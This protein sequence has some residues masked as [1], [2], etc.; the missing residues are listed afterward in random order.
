MRTKCILLICLLL[1]VFSAQT[2]SV[3][4]AA[5]SALAVKHHNLDS[6]Y[7]CLD[8]AVQQSPRYVAER[9]GRIAK[10]TQQ[11]RSCRSDEAR[12]KLCFSLFREYSAYKNDS[13]VNYL[14]RCISIAQRMG[15]KAKEGN[16]KALL[17]FQSSTT[18]DY[19]ESYSLL[20]KMD[21]TQLDKEGYCNYLWSSQHLYNELA[22]Y[23]KVPS[24]KK[25]YE[26]MLKKVRNLISKNFAPND[27]RYLQMQ[28]VEARD[29]QQYERALALNDRRMNQVKPGSHEYAI[30]AYY[31]AVIYKNM[32][33]D[34]MAMYYFL[35]T[36]LCDVR[37][38]V[39]DQGSLWE[40]ANLLS[41]N[42]QEFSRSYAYMK[43]AWNSAVTFNT[44]VRTRQIMPLLSN[45]EDTYQREVMQSNKQL[46]I[47]IVISVILLLLVLSLLL[48]VN[49][50]R[51]RLSLAHKKLELANEQL[52]HANSQLEYANQQLA[53]ANESLE[54]TNADLQ[55]S[56][57]N[58][59]QAYTE[60]GESNKMKEVYIGR[61]L[62]LCAIYVDKI[63]TLRKRVI[64]LVRQRE[65]TKLLDT[66]QADHE[67]IGELY[68]YFDSA[69]LKLF[70]DFV[71][72]FNALLKPEERIQLEDDRKL[73]TT[74]RIFALIRLGIEDSSKI[75]EFLHYSVN[76]IY[77]YRAKVKNGA[78]CDR[79]TFEQKVKEIG[80]K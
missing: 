16:A 26:L 33:E 61:F 49:K 18:G 64:K 42:L 51:H 37:T 52:A 59:K 6:L 79:E 72:E 53:H 65:F 20:S 60:L 31:R 22:Y 36:A 75:A 80:M 28:E 9:E 76:T 41:L 19:V 2:F 21:T 74:I 1:Q 29:A 23:S 11:L 12:Y 17:A 44:G 70:P 5:S 30:V 39:M 68:D 48:Y 14:N 47:M 78:L 58:L 8:E 32:G 46:K 43:F 54:Q 3:A 66:M 10:L 73:T 27:D 25:H 45:M 15:D 56:N 35:T 50:Q 24:L 13:A 55:L 62:R 4:H 57:E 71:E 63:E 40:L 38:A 34:E 7:V 69:F 77:N 67:Y